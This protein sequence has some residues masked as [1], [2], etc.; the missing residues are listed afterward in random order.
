MPRPDFPRTI[1]EFQKHFSDEGECLKYLIESRWPNGFSCPRCG[2]R[3]FYWKESRSLLQCKA[4]SYQASVTAGTIMHRSRQPLTMWFLAAY[5]VTTHTPGMSAL[6]FQR[7]VGLTS[8]QTAFTMLHKLRAA[9]VRT[10][11]TKLEG[12]VEVDETYVGGREAGKSGRG[13]GGKVLVAGAAEIR[14]QTVTRIRLKVAPTASKVSLQN[15]IKENVEPGSSI[16]TDAWAG[17]SGLADLGYKH[18]A[19]VE[20]TP[21]RAG[22]ILPH[23]HRVFSNLKTWLVGTHHGVSEQHLPAYLNEYVFRLNRRQ[24]PMAAFQTCLGLIAER[25]GPT[26]RGLYGVKKGSP[27]WVHPNPKSTRSNYA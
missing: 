11:R 7:Q 9:L 3:E 19:T 13:A 16:K 22:I 23:I 5:L 2:D 4:C 24:T 26:Y 17:Y 15:F 21:E 1:M 25:R 10:E 27:E 18:S 14:G 8:Y 6:Q 12:T 20:G